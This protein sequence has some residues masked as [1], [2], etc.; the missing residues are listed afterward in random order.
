MQ[1]LQRA[2][3]KR[4]LALIPARNSQSDDSDTTDCEEINEI[5]SEDETHCSSSTPSLDSSLERMNLF[6]SDGSDHDAP[7]SPALQNAPTVSIT[8]ELPSSVMMQDIPFSPV[9][10]AVFPSEN[11]T[12]YNS[13]PSL[14]SIPL[15]PSPAVQSPLSLQ[16]TP[17]TSQHLQKQI[18]TRS[19]RRERNNRPRLVAK[20][21]KRTPIDFKWKKTRFIHGA[22]VEAMPFS[23]PPAEL[24][25]PRQYFA[26]FFSDEI[27]SDIVTQTNMY[28]VQKL[29]RSINVNAKELNN[30]LLF[31]M[32]CYLD[33][34]STQLRYAP[35]ADI[36]SLKKY[37]L[38]R[39][40]IHFVDSNEESLDRFQKV[41]PVV[42]KVRLN[43][44]LSA[45]EENQFS[46]DEMTLP[47]KGKKAGNRRQY[48]AKKPK[49]WGFKAFV[50]SGVSGYI[51]D[52]LL[53]GGDDTF[54]N[55][56]FTDREETLGFG[57]K[58]VVALCQ[59]IKNKPCFVY[60]DNYYTSLE[61]VVYLRNELGIFSLGTI[62]SNRLRGC[63]NVIDD[64]KKMK[65]KGRG[66][67]SQ[68]VCNENKIAV[69][70]WFDN[71]PKPVK[72]R[73][74]DEIRYDGM[75]HLPNL[76]SRGRCRVCKDGQSTVMCIKYN[77]RLCLTKK[78]NC[79]YDFH[80]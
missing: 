25:S 18:T 15:L 26:L 21:I 7:M 22:T 41:R 64:D 77:V 48:N 68:I 27:I 37:Q 5:P 44:L 19:V 39:R 36:M 12:D 43:C 35:V 65:K 28:S 34:W 72:S 10:Q 69:V 80:V 40:Y 62:K 70:K 8:K 54:R 31:I 63:Q 78:R 53:Y 46:I 17:N 30:S 51:Y 38:I 58:V 55:I 61:L 66:S 79:F 50:R 29:G 67:F 23:H 56:Q 76:E 49:K 20:R 60:F 32:P 6:D 52:F 13:I 14:S 9:L 2:R 45:E 71:K 75:G 73:P 33:Y 3:S 16:P 57:G 42:E 74:I 11:V 59:S 1:V 4:I 24:P 47:Y